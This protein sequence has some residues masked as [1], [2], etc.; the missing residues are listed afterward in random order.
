VQIVPCGAARVDPGPENGRTGRCYALAGVLADQ[1]NW[2]G[3][4]RFSTDPLLYGDV[5]EV[6]IYNT[7]RTATQ[8]EASAATGPDMLPAE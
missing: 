1:N 7:A 5:H 8:V 4:S 3:R 6:R 2:I